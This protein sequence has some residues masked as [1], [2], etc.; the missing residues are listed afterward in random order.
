MKT[1]VFSPSGRGRPYNAFKCPYCGKGYTDR[2]SMLAHSISCSLN[3]NRERIIQ[4]RKQ[5]K[6]QK[7]QNWVQYPF[8]LHC[9]RCGKQYVKVMN[10]YSFEHDKYNT[11][12]SKECRDGRTRMLPQKK[13]RIIHPLQQKQKYNIHS[14][15][16]Y[17]SLRKAVSIILSFKNMAANA[18]RGLKL[19]KF[20][21][22]KI[23]PE[24][25]TQFFTKSIDNMYCSKE[26]QQKAK[27]FAQKK[28]EYLESLKPLKVGI[29]G[30]YGGSKGIYR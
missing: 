3:P 10:K 17:T 30:W 21:I 9:R 13:K 4:K 2:N 8:I 20:T 7:N 24:C 16:S 23:C 26:C 27:F 6:L 19:T 1:K 11:Y 25:K 14:Y 18:S 12:C 15:Y 29:S 22:I 28:Q 5:T